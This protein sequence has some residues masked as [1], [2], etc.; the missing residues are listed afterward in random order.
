MRI[1]NLFVS[2][3][4][5]YFVFLFLLFNYFIYFQS[6]VQMQCNSA[7]VFILN[8]PLRLQTVSSSIGCFFVENFICVWHWYFLNC[9]QI[10]RDK[11]ILEYFV[12]STNRSGQNTYWFN[13]CFEFR[14]SVLN[15]IWILW[16]SSWLV[17]TLI[18]VLLRWRAPAIVISVLG[19]I[20]FVT[21]VVTLAI[22]IVSK[23]VTRKIN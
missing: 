23:C 3:A 14:H 8:W 2:I 10:E 7:F 20:H 21:I 5:Y 16:W 22:T 17:I 12:L 15:F 19:S 6:S 9:K 1:A 18:S 13:I 4:M 11:W